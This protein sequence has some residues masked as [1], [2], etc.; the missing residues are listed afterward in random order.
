M[1]MHPRLAEAA[2]SIAGVSPTSTTSAGDEV[3]KAL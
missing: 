1:F 3:R 2:A